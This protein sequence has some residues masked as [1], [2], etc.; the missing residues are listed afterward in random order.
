MIEHQISGSTLTEPVADGPPTEANGCDAG[1]WQLPP[2]LIPTMDQIVIEDD[3]PLDSLQTEKQQR[4]LT[5]PLYSSW[6]GPEKGRD[7]L[8]MA[9]VGLFYIHGSPALVPDIMLALDVPP[10]DLRVKENRTYCIWTRGKAPDVALEIVSDRYGGELYYKFDRYAYIGIPYYVIYDP[11]EILGEGRLRAFVLRAETGKYVPAEAHWFERVGLGLL[12]WPGIYE[13]HEGLWLRWCDR[14]G[15]V[16]PTGRERA[17]AAVQRAEQEHQRAE[18]AVQ[19][20]EQEHQRAET[21]VQRAEQEHQRAE[22][23]HQRAEQ[24][25]QRRERLEAQL[26]ALGINPLE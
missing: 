21:A 10:A 19:R 20:A 25:R 26:R 11:R 5:E 7:F 17:D 24:E 14:N 18:T 12:E 23:E 1:N 6:S 13:E 3:T 22:Q 2:E 9:N 15:Q 8:I 4:L 16:I